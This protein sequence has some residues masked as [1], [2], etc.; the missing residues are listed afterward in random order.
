MS[1]FSVLPVYHT[2]QLQC[3]GNVVTVHPCELTHFIN[4]QLATTM[5]IQIFQHYRFPISMVWYAAKI[6][7]GF[8][9]CT[10]LTF[11]LWQ[12]VAWNKIN[13]QVS[14]LH[15]K[16]FP[17]YTQVHIF[18]IHTLLN[19]LS[20]QHIKSKRLQ[21]YYYTPSKI[22][23]EWKWHF[24]QQNQWFLSLLHITTNTRNEDRNYENS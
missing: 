24:L 10:R 13:I 21:N 1:T 18:L 19:T 9:W 7:E 6:W 2:Q 11:L 17:F 14:I 22:I 3:G 12:Q 15:T 16:I 23:L 8:L 5:I 20:V 4:G